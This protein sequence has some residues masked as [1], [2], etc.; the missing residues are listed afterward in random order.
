MPRR[1]PS[2][3]LCAAAL[4]AMGAAQPA[5]SEQARHGASQES[6]SDAPQGSDGRS[7]G[8]MG[9][10]GM[11]GRMQMGP[12]TMMGGT[13]MDG[14]MMD[15]DMMRR[16]MS[17]MGAHHG[18]SGMM[19]GPMPGHGDMLG[20]FAMGPVPHVEGHIAFL[21]AE[22]GITARQQQAWE[23]FAQALRASAERANARHESMMSER[24]QSGAA[25]SSPVQRLE[26]MAQQLRARLES[27][28]SMRGALA[29]LYPQ[30]S[31]RQKRTLQQ[32]TLPSMAMAMGGASRNGED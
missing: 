11:M 18:R 9:R 23:A 26:T 31:D 15:G 16:M 8:D 13:M 12:G 22:L 14:T 30:L 1:S 6:A 29:D 3:I 28:Q 19:A 20:L 5:M 4:L 2:L 24:Q 25:E 27:V 10:G 17:M 7:M 32:L 21:G